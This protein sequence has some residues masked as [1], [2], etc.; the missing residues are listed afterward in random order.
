MTTLYSNTYFQQNT[1]SA[2]PTWMKGE[3]FDYCEKSL[4]KRTSL[5]GRKTK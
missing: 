3:R 5:F 4:R 1:T 2:V